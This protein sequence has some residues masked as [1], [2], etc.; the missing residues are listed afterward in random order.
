[1]IAEDNAEIA[2]RRVRAEG[3]SIRIQSEGKAGGLRTRVIG[4]A[5]WQK[6]VSMTL[7]P[8]YLRFNLCDSE[9]SKFV[10]LPDKLNVPRQKNHGG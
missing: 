8:D 10:L 2:R 3:D 4:Q 5:K 9:N 7:T 1:M 6:S